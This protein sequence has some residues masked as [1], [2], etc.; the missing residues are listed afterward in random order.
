MKFLKSLIKTFFNLTLTSK[1]FYLFRS[2]YFYIKDYNYISDVLYGDG[3]NRLIE[4]Y[5]HIQLKRDWI[6]RL[7]GVI[8]PN[9]D[10]QGNFD[11]NNIIIELNDDYTNNNEYVL[12]WIYKQLSLIQNL[13]NLKN[14]YNYIS[15]DLKH[16]GP[17]I[18]DNYLIVFDITSRKIISK[19]F[20]QVI[21]QLSI[22]AI[23][24]CIFCYA[25]GYAIFS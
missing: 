6:G 11:V 4:T 15:M 8:N 7:Y 17:P 24:A 12:N 16:I 19:Y 5:L 14:F 1:I 3:F 22:Y 10:I 2:I 18:G 13:F 9:I 20:K 23:A 21:I 25:F